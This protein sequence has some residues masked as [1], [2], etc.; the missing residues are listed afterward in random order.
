MWEPGELGKGELP[1]SDGFG[2]VIQ[3]R[4]IQHEQVQTWMTMG[5]WAAGD[6]VAFTVRPGMHER[7]RYREFVRSCRV[8][9]LPAS[10][11]S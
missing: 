2:G 10:S 3:E 8:L 5:N 11:A 4:T 1:G 7:E 6:G 9:E